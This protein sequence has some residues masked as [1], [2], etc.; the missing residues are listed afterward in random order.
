MNTLKIPGKDCYVIRRIEK[1]HSECHSDDDD[2]DDDEEDDDD[3][4]NN[5]TLS[6][7]FVRT[8]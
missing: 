7:H 4:N 1:F 2:D 6:L 8:L 5:K 3:D